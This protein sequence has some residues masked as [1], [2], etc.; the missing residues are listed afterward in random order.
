MGQEVLDA[1]S[2]VS[3][4]MEVVGALST[5]VD[6]LILKEEYMIQRDG[7]LFKA[8]IV[9]NELMDKLILLDQSLDT[10]WR[11]IGVVESK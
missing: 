9:Y 11:T 5:A 3:V 1:V 10:L 2:K 8:R 7:Y 4:N 6:E